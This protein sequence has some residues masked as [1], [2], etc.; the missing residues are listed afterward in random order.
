MKVMTKA[1]LLGAIA[2]AV[3]KLEAGKGSIQRVLENTARHIAEHGD[4]TVAN[5]VIEAMMASERNLSHDAKGAVRWL[6]KYCGLKI[7]AEAGEFNGWKGA[8]YIRDNF[9][10]GRANQYWKSITVAKPFEFDLNAEIVKLVGRAT[11]AQEREEGKVIIEDDQLDALRSC[12]S[13]AA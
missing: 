9:A 5:S 13:V 3:A 11:K 6:E 1:E 7:D 4:W 12:I 10:E 2:A 8:Q